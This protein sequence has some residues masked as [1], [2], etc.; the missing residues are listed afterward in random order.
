MSGS[1][2]TKNVPRGPGNVVETQDELLGRKFNNTAKFSNTAR[3]FRNT[4]SWGLPAAARHP[5]SWH[6]NGKLGQKLE[7]RHL[8]GDDAGTLP[9]LMC[10][11]CQI[12]S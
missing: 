9:C 10:W 11:V 5:W 3:R 2:L 8:Q 7:P 12:M 4:A 1:I 6:I